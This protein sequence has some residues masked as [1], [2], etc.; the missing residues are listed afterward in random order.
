MKQV[1]LSGQGQID[2]FDVPI[3]SKLDNTVLVK[4]AYSLISTG[5]E[6]AAVTSKSGMLGLYEK[7]MS[8]KDRIDQVWDMTKKQGV[9][10]TL[11]MVRGKL[12][13]RTAIGYTCAGV[14]AELENDKL[15]YSVGQ[16]VAC[17]GAGFAS[18]AEYVTVP[19]NLVVPIP[20][21]VSYEEAAFGA[22]A[23][24]A[25][26]GIRRLEAS[27]GEKIGVI[28]LGLIGQLATKLLVAMGYSVVGLDLSPERAAYADQGI[29]VDAWSSSPEETLSRIKVLTD[30]RGLDGVVV[31]ASGKSDVAVNLAFDMCRPKG[32][33]SIVGDVGLSLKRAKM[34]AKELDLRMSC[35]YGAGRYDPNYE[36]KGQDYPLGH[37][38]W[39][40]GRNLEFFL[41]LL[42]SKRL[43]ISDLISGKFEVENAV[44]AYVK[45]KKAEPDTYGVLID[46]GLNEEAIAPSQSD[47][48]QRHAQPNVTHQGKI[49]I[50][51]I[52]AGGFTKGVH[53][54]NF[55]KL[56]KKFQIAGIASRTGATASLLAKKT[57]ATISTSDYKL[58]L[59][60]D[61]IDAVLISTRHA[62]HGGIALEALQ[63]GKH[64]FI[65][66]PMCL[67]SLQ[68]QEI[69]ELAQQKGLI[70]RVGFN[71]RYAPMLVAA[72]KAVGTSGHRVMT[73]HVNIGSSGTNHWSNTS[74]EGGRFLGE[75]T[76]FLDLCNWFAGE[77][78]KTVSAA[79]MGKVDEL[80]PNV[81]TTITYENGTIC[82]VLYTTEGSPN[83][84]KEYYEMHG[85]G[86]SVR[87][88]DFEK[89]V[90][91]G[92]RGPLIP[93][94]KALKGQLEELEEFA[95]AISGNS[96]VADPADEKA[97]WVATWMVEAAI[98]S[99]NQNMAISLSNE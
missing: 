36:L 89:L 38:R 42:A 87:C 86:V 26:Q 68:G 41:S 83:M 23:C 58:L 45:I 91:K 73:C 63:A 46:Y 2:V 88:D 25:M 28:G 97:G 19:K 59:Q 76:H 81:S 54:P 30:G 50:G 80:N 1:F 94:K 82:H 51:L 93:I 44:Q 40:E 62:T 4:N 96:S 10:K 27:P 32:C 49:K 9:A 55:Q 18:H 39:T 99:A 47:R 70:V 11:E 65:E 3:P 84:G 31:C 52:G 66:K 85:N 98:K 7:V 61:D 22:I 77:Y 17:M 33:V 43:D 71:R 90:I 16:R 20:D 57:G 72:K 13:D 12:G 29:G 35:S 60:D 5:T 48:I 21:N 34:Y 53:V 37:V 95:N 69:A 56:G 15:P 14:I 24:I 8:S 92:G 6:G 64:V 75:G 79:F 78:P 67:T 74:E